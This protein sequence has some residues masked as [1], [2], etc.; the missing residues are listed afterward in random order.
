MRVGAWAR[1]ALR[2]RWARHDGCGV[3][4]RVWP[5]RMAGEDGWRG[6]P[7]RLACEDCW[8]GAGWRYT[9][10]GRGA[11]GVGQ[12]EWEHG[13]QVR[14]T[15][16]CLTCL[17][18]GKHERGRGRERAQLQFH[19]VLP[20]RMLIPLPRILSRLTPWLNRRPHPPQSPPPTSHGL[21]RSP[22]C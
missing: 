1:V 5:A 13:Q 18:C 10:V 17:A 9:M 19:M 4:K 2:G 14:A 20:P 12:N 3:T 22:A 15:S 6:W 8:P 7:V 11:T 21:A 16:G